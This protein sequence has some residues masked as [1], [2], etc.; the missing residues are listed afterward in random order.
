M[1]DTAWYTLLMGHI[2]TLETRAKT[3]ST[4]KNRKHSSERIQAITRGRR[5]QF[6]LMQAGQTFGQ[7]T[8][9]GDPAL[10]NHQMKY[11]CR[12]SCGSVKRIAAS[13]LRLG[14]STKC[15]KC[16]G[17]V[18]SRRAHHRNKSPRGRWLYSAATR[19]DWVETAFEELFE[20]QKGI[21][22][23]CLGALNPKRTISCIDHNHGTGE[24]RGIVHRGCN[25]L[26][27][28]LERC[29]EIGT[30]VHEYLEGF[31]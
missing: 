20:A 31:K 3:S 9:I 18:N 2:P 1:S 28:W 4:L 22:P 10:E 27:G 8:V 19:A 23:I 26:V 7:W 14:K 21:C 16:S 25:V 17:T 6:P 30:R 24:M 13:H 29:P 5:A 11:T 12:C 15:I